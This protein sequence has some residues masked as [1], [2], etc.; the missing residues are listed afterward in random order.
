[1]YY[2]LPK[3]QS[4]VKIQAIQ[5]IVNPENFLTGVQKNYNRLLAGMQEATERR[6]VVEQLQ[7]DKHAWTPL[8]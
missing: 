2:F 7:E 4:S 3:Y 6:Y 1:M 8:I 5:K